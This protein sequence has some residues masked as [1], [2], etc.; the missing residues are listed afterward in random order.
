MF[1][2]IEGGSI[3]GGC[4]DNN[5]KRETAMMLSLRVVIMDLQ[6]WD[7]MGTV[8]VRQSKT[9]HVD[10]MY[11]QLFTSQQRHNCLKNAFF[12]KS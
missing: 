1:Y 4:M 9:I 3:E 12:V 11:T 10:T 8:E 5:G 2:V 6:M 7:L